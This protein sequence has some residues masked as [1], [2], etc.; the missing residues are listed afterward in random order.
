[1]SVSGRVPADEELPRAV[2]PLDRRGVH[3][4]AAYRHQN[5][6]FPAPARAQRS[7][8]PRR[9][10]SST[11]RCG[12]GARSAPPRANA[13]V[14]ARPPGPPR[15]RARRCR[16]GSASSMPSRPSARHRSRAGS[17]RS[18]PTAA[19]PVQGDVVGTADRVEGHRRRAAT[20]GGHRHE[21]P[22]E[23]GVGVR[24]GR[25]FGGG[26]KLLVAVTVP[27]ATSASGAG[28]PGAVNMTGV[29]TSK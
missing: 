6:S 3:A 8:R 20:R 15:T 13:A 25:D 19:C 23:R 26:P 5:F 29:F 28:K 11:G 9:T 12:G 10:R 4:F 24:E 16:R 21:D 7:V 2:D 1:L 17:R 14:R 27:K 22:V 18:D